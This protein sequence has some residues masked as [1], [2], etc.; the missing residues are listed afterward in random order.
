MISKPTD[1]MISVTDDPSSYSHPFLA[2]TAT[3]YW[4]ADWL[5]GWLLVDDD[6]TSSRLLQYVHMKDGRME[7]E[8]NCY[9]C[10][11]KKGG[12]SKFSVHLHMHTVSA[13]NAYYCIR[14][15]S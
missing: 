14:N 9:V 5:A 3:V 8:K 11:L 2:S 4:L 6:M 10:S 13:N 15:I 7:R 12:S 1:T